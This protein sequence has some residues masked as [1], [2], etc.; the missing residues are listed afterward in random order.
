MAGNI[1]DLMN[2]AQ[3]ASFDPSA[4]YRASL[5]TLLQVMGGQLD[6]LSP[7]NPVVYAIENQ[8][9]LIGG[10]TETM[11]SETRRLLQVQALTPE[12][13]YPHMA[14]IHFSNIF[15]LPSTTVF[16]LV[17]NK[18]E[19]LNKMVPVPGTMSR[20]VTIPRNSYFT[21][22]DYVFGIHYPIDIIEQVHGALRVAY[23]T[24]VTTPL[25]DLQT[26]VLKFRTVQ[27]DDIEYLAIDIPVFQFAITSKTPTVTQAMTFSYNIALPDLYYATR[28]YRTKSDGTQ[29]EIKVTYSEE[30]YDPLKATAVVRILDGQVNI[31]IPQIYINSGLIAGELRIDVY[32]TKGPV[33]TTFDSYPIGSIGYRFRDLN[34]RADTTFS[35]PMQK[36]GTCTILGE[37][38]VTGGVLGMTFEEL[39]DAVISDG[40]GDPNLPI[41]PAQVKNYLN[42]RGYDIIKNTDIVTDR[43]FLATRNM[44]EPAGAG[45]L[46]AANASIET[47]NAAFTDLITNSAVIDNGTSVTITPR[48]V[49][50]LDDGI[51]K[52]MSDSE[53]ATVRAMRSDLLAAHVTTNS[54][55]YSPYYNVLDKANNQFRLAAYYLD[56]PAVE[57]QT[58]VQDNEGTLLSVNTNGYL[59][60]K[61]DTGYKLTLKTKS[62][63][64]YK[65]LNDSMVQ[66]LLGFISP[67]EDDPCWVVGTQISVGS[68]KERTFEFILDSRFSMNASDRIDFRNFKMYDT[69]DKTIYADLEQDFMVVYTTTEQMG[70]L[71]QPGTI[72]AKLPRFLIP[73]N[74]VGITEEKLSLRFGSALS[75]LWTRARSIASSILYE[76]HATD[77]ML[78][79]T[80]D[81]FKTNPETGGDIWFVDGKPQRILLHAKDDPYLDPENNPIVQY[82]KGTVVLDPDTGEPKVKD[83][84]YLKH[85]FELFLIEGVYIFSNDQIA[86]DYRNSVAKTVAAWVTDEVSGLEKVTM[87]KSKAYFYPKTVF[88]TVEVVVTDGI[89]QQIPAGQSFD[90]KLY[91]PAEVMQ[92][93]ELKAQLK[94]Q[95]IAV[96]SEYLKNRTLAVSDIIELLKQAYGSDVI[97]VQVSQFGPAAN[98][99]VMQL[100]NEVHRCGIRKRLVSRDDEKLVVEEAITVSYQSIQ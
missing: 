17:L 99:P 5:R 21:I 67:T 66:C 4:T 54:Y 8:A 3:A 50:R 20:K 84:R 15:N 28:V 48:A 74:S 82:P 24:D 61:T 96:I 19:I 37:K 43:V 81:V 64:E 22:S 49:Y 45:L 27:R 69:T 93:D 29:E 94:K 86:I 65:E 41:T 85:R 26:N 78:R 10:F 46:T 83:A 34:K 92:N 68:D 25:Q 70:N 60:T 59:L 71:F 42:R 100:V 76:T 23:D 18:A 47:M 31:M 9:A 87:D 91:V 14:D 90:V 53:L 98:I 58:F 38:P 2:D 51:L 33:S 52:L 7:I 6:N 44:P 97:D 40:I 88:G 80:K 56:D 32:S 16:T 79:Y 63:D 1:R 73:M 39:R 89:V 95:T 13:L 55:L 57:S 72:D 77:V 11:Q 30:I 35:A 36:L 12:D 75:N 62:S